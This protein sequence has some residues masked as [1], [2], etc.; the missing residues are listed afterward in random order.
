MELSI[1]DLVRIVSN[2]TSDGFMNLTVG[3]EAVISN[4]NLLDEYPIELEGYLEGLL[5]SEVELIRS[6]DGPS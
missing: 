6:A 5:E 4:I 1:G 2:N 3:T